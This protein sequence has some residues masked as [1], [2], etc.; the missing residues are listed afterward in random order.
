M[1][2]ELD[3][4]LVDVTE[5]LKKFRIRRKVRPSEKAI[6]AFDGEYCSF[7]ALNVAV[8]ARATGTWPGIARFSA[9]TLVALARCPPTIP[10]FAVRITGNTLTLGPMNVTCEWQ[11][12]SHVLTHALA[13]PDWIQALG[14]KFTATRAQILAEKVNKQIDAA[15]HKLDILVRKV[16][17]SLA[18]LGV[19]ERDIR[20]LIGSRLAER[21]AKLT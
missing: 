8:A 20:D 3:V 19:T 16:G 9:S 12:V 5:G 1:K 21:Y 2:H 6:V 4:D 13:A 10:P 11:P 15:E 14:L 7:E 17:K 18:P